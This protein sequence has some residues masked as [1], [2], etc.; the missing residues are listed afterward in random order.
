MGTRFVTNPCYHTPCDTIGLGKIDAGVNSME[1]VQAFTHATLV[2]ISELAE[3]DNDFNDV[4]I[5][6]DNNLIFSIE[7]NP[8]PSSGIFNIITNIISPYTLINYGL[9]GKILYQDFNFVDGL[10]DIS[11]LP[12]GIY[13]INIGNNSINISKRIIIR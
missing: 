9:D 4:F 2:A 13:L 11:F 1:L 10:V 7:I 6:K 3:I 12:K 8:N 5:N